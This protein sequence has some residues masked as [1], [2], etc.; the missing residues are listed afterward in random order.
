MYFVYFAQLTNLGGRT[1][2][3]TKRRMERGNHRRLYETPLGFPKTLV[4]NFL[5][6]MNNLYVI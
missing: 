5:G 6:L 2:V 3:G 4:S 1:V